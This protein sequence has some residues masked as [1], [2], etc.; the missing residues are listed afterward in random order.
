MGMDRCSTFEAIKDE[1]VDFLNLAPL[2]PVAL[3]VPGQ[4]VVM[5]PVIESPIVP[6]RKRLPKY[7][8]YKQHRIPK[9]DKLIDKNRI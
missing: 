2:C 1:L 5:E 3:S 9:N 6:K 8:G 4:T 7:K